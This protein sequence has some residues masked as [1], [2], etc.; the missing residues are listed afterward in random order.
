[1]IKTINPQN[2]EAQH[3]PST[4]NKKKIVPR[5]IKIKLLKINGKGGILKASREKKNFTCKGTYDS[6]LKDQHFIK[7]HQPLCSFTKI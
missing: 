4:R 2:Q 6:Q 3:I 5:C 1:M 7:H